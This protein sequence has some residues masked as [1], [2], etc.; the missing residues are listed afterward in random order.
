M[1]K[2]FREDLQNSWEAQEAL[3]IFK[4]RNPNYNCYPTYDHLVMTHRIVG[5]EIAEGRPITRQSLR[6]LVQLIMPMLKEDAVYLS[7]EMLVYSPLNDIMG[8]WTPASVRNLF[9]LK[10]TGIKSGKA[11]VPPTLFVA[12]GGRLRVWALAK[13][14]RP[15]P[16][17]TLYYSPYFN[18]YDNGTCMGD[19]KVPQTTGLQ[20]MRD[21]EALFFNSAFTLAAEPE[22]KSITAKELWKSLI[23]KNAKKFPVECLVPV[24]GMKAGDIANLIK[25][26][27]L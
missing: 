15:S 5:G 14:E 25:R 8:W 9:F 27:R 21:W 26:S 23:E 2:D 4:N 12:S 16:K 18:V 11:P 24:K 19:M 1:T 7:P 20:A 6:D 17:S 10:N 3:I 13:N 22:L